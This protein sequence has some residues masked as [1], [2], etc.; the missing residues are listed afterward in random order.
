M[1]GRKDVKS[2]LFRERECEKSEA[3]GEGRKKLKIF[4]DD[5]KRNTTAQNGSVR[6][7]RS[8]HL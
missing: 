4:R 5:N 1:L 2:S 8:G 7:R 6:S 3:G